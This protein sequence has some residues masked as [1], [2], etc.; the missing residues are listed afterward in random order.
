MNLI[1]KL[2]VQR[3]VLGLLTLLAVSA[4]IFLSVE[5]LPGDLAEELLGQSA[6]PETVA[7]LR[8]ELG[9]DRPAFERYVGWLG[10]ALQADF[11][12]SLANGRKISEL[13][14]PRLLN[15]LYLAAIAALIAVPFAISLG[16]VAALYRNT[17]FDRLINTFTLASISFPEFFVAYILILLFAVELGIL[18]SVSNINPSMGF[19][20]F[21]YR[22]ILPSL[23]LTVVVTAHMMRMTRAA[24]VNLLALPYI[25]MARLKG[26]SQSRVII[27][28]ALPNAIAPIA[29]VVALNLAYLI[30]GVVIVEVVF[31]YPGLGQLLVD[32][33]SKRDLP[34]VQA[35]CLIFAATYILLN[36]TADIISIVSNPRLLKPK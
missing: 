34:V 19:W 35:S 9:L 16:V 10:S 28:H 30:T 20:E 24:I 4:V 5:L 29:N 18:P 22:T 15:T 17:L 26:A 8:K 1:L 11:G 12:T 6:T 23:T 2:T 21:I 33:V 36:L 7:A 32:S 14:A 25:E 3:L 31:L 27:H 13:I